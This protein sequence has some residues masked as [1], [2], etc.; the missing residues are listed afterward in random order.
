MTF[1]EAK[2]ALASKLDISLTDIASNSLF[3]ESDLETW[4]NMATQKAWDFKPWPFTQRTITGTTVDAQYY[5]HPTALM[6]QSLFR[7]VING[8]HYGNPMDFDDYIRW[9]ADNPTSTDRVWSMHETYVFINRLSYGVG[10]VLDMTGKKYPPHLSASGDLL[11]FSPMTDNLEHSG[12]STIVELAYAEALAS[13]KLK[14]LT[15]AVTHRKTAYET[16]T[17]LWQ[18]FAQQKAAQQT[19]RQMFN[20]PNMFGGRSQGP[21]GNFDINQ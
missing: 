5:D 16:L 4:L 8:Y 11:P 20:T 21:I 14:R 13:D 19:T 10:E 6:L 1:L 17:L 9:K 12:N 3:T 15:E 18:P 7:L 2:T